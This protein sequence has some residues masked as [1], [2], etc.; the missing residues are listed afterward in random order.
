MNLLCS[1]DSF[2]ISMSLVHL[3]QP[4]HAE[5]SNLGCHLCVKKYVAGFEITVDDPELRILM[6][7]MKELLLLLAARVEKNQS[8]NKTSAIHI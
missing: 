4:C 7:E 1:S 6:K 3:K 5:I 2:S 8:T